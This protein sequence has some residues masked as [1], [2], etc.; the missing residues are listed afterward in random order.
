V[1]RAEVGVTVS[2][3]ASTEMVKSFLTAAL[4]SSN[5]PDTGA[6]LDR[7]YCIED[8]EPSSRDL[9][10][11]ICDQFLHDAVK[12]GCGEATHRSGVGIDSGHAGHDL[13]LTLVGHGAGFWDGDWD[14]GDELTEVVASLKGHDSM[15]VLPLKDGKHLAFDGY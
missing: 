2:N 12:A 14:M 8:F 6:P 5:H 9:A 1:A 13:W 7:D 4:W 3:I 10:Q 11:E 15:F